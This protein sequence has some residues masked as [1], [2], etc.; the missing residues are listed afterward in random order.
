MKPLFPTETKTPVAAPAIPVSG[1]DLLPAVAPAHPIAQPAPATTADNAF[2]VDDAAIESLGATAATNLPGVSKKLLSTTKAADADVFG[3]QLNELISTAK[4]LDPKAL[5]SGVLARVASIFSSAKE[6][7]LSRYSS[8]ESRMDDLVRQL[9][10]HRTL[11]M[12]RIDDFET[13]YNENF[14]YHQGLEVAVAQGEEWLAGLD[15]HLAQQQGATDSFAAQRLADLKSRRDRL[16]KRID[17][18]KR[19]MLLSKQMAPQI[20]LGQDN[21]RALTA[22]F[23]DIV[24]VAI[25][26]WRNVFTSY[27]LQ[28][29]AKQS[30]KV[31]NVAYDATNEAF[32]AQADQLQQNTEDIARLKQRSVVDIE[33]LEHVQ[34]Q[35]IATFDVHDKVAEEGRA[36]R[37]AELPRMVELERELINRFVPKTN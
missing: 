13:L 36:R 35:L 9:E 28:L 33:T 24:S 20:R 4:G 12:G 26:A 14:A 10:K 5:K 37:K 30:A 19:G 8:V 3:T 15:A 32:R 23:A 6:T 7:M 16:E 27:I 25:P 11:H 1:A 18:L 31:G 34:K 21:A 2:V 17:D 22:A 29:E